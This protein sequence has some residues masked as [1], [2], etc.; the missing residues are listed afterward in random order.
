MTRRTKDFHMPRKR[1]PNSL[2]QSAVRLR[3][4]PELGFQ[5]TNVN[6]SLLRLPKRTT[7]AQ[8]I[9]WNRTR[10][11]DFSKV[12]CHYGR[13]TLGGQPSRTWKSLSL[14]KTSEDCGCQ[15]R[16]TSG[17]TR[18]RRIQSKPLHEVQAKASNCSPAK[19]RAVRL[20]ALYVWPGEYAHDFW[21]QEIPD[22]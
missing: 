13:V 18:S 20:S 21:L 6:Q 16:R 1:T 10:V 2:R 7:Q 11:N 9:R 3:R 15:V 19:S 17:L 22:D 8:K 14:H 12:S 5:R 4:L